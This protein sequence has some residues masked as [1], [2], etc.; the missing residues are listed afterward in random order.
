MIYA[1]QGVREYNRGISMQ[2]MKKILKQKICM[3]W[4]GCQTI[5][6]LAHA[7]LMGSSI[8]LA[9]FYESQLVLD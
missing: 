7:K 3:K 9:L 4:Y 8:G 1:H 6:N 5:M 2:M